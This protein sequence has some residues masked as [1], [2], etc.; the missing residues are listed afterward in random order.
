MPASDVKF[1]VVNKSAEFAAVIEALA[2]MPPSARPSDPAAFE[3]FM[4]D[5]GVTG[6]SWPHGQPRAIVYN[7][8]ADDV[9]SVSVPSPNAIAEGRNMVQEVGINQQGGRYPLDDGYDLAYS[10][11]RVVINDDAVWNE[12]YRTRLGDYTIGKCM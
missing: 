6:F 12:L 1:L 5:H 8:M 11:G 10:T 9:L 4:T 2:A 7:D 3:Q